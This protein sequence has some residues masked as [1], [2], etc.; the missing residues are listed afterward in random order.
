MYNLQPP[1]DIVEP[2]KLYDALVDQATHVTFG[3]GHEQNKEPGEGGLA[4]F[5]PACPQPGYNLPDNWENDPAQFAYKRQI[6]NDGNFKAQNSHSAR[7]EQDVCLY[8]GEGYM[9]STCRNH[10]AQNSAE[11]NPRNLRASGIAA[12]AC[13]RHGC[14][15]PNS[16]V[17]FQVGEQ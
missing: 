12:C 15:V 1:H 14:F 8:D 4:L 16:V 2:A 6:V 10:K 9:K 3:Y 11:R 17:D 7:P 5:C 13:A